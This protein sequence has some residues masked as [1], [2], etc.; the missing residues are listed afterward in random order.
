MTAPGID[1][2]LHVHAGGTSVVID[3]PERTAPALAYW[4]PS[5]GDLDATELD[6]V[7][8][9]IRPQQRVGDIDHPSP[10]SLVPVQAEGWTGSPG[11][12]GHRRRAA[13]APSF[14]CIS[15]SISTDA[16]AMRA[17]LRC[18]DPDA[19]LDLDITLDVLPSGLVR[20]RL[21][22]RN[23][24]DGAYTV[25]ALRAVFPVPDAATEL[26]DLTGRWMRERIPQRHPLRVGRFARESR[27]G[28]PG[29][30]A[31]LLLVAGEPGFGFERGPV[32]AVHV[33][34]SGNHELAAERT[35][36]AGT[37]LTGAELPLPGEIVVTAGHEYASPWVYASHGNGLDELASRFHEFLRARESHPH[38]PRPVVMNVWEAVYFDHELPKLS[39]LAELGASIGAE[40]FMLDDGWFLGRRND[41]CALGDWYVDPDVWPEGLAPIIDR[42]HELGMAFGIWVEPEMVSVDSVLARKHPEWLLGPGG[43]TPPAAKWQQV[44]DLSNP[45]A[46]AYIFERLDWLLR[47]HDVQYLKWDHNRDVL[48]PGAELTGFATL[49]EHTL[50][51]YRLMDELRRRHPDVEFENCASGGARIDLEILS[52]T[53]RTWVSDCADPMERAIVQQYTGLLM[54]LEMTGNDISAATSHTTGRTS[55]I[56]L[57]GGVAILGHLGIQW[58]LTRTTEQE[59]ADLAA[60]VAAYKRHRGLLHSGKAVS[61]DHHDPSVLIRGVVA[62]DRSRALFTLAQLT[63]S[64]AP[65]G[66]RIRFPGLDPD[67][68]YDVRVDTPA[69]AVRSRAYTPAPWVVDGIR[70]T[71]R[72]LAAVGLEAPVLDPEQVIIITLD[73]VPGI[74]SGTR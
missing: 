43:R 1:R 62:P 72:T 29:A 26:L 13:F 54:P 21:V 48:E 65:S 37:V 42:V 39:E 57:R 63:S 10:V 27:K 19:G 15:H 8:R 52:R 40:L 66:G 53:E 46:Y 33:A 20:Q 11:L 55:W 32:Y 73:S 60:W 70:L 30:D 64:L 59:R 5:L 51:V 14:R 58:D 34:W 7:V 24:D 3:L 61:L 9:A 25:Q 23:V 71:G 49:H 50:A 4:G 17:V 16:G 18:S 12:E 69:H 45:E 35:I 74:P 36:L 67:T 41:R 6:A 28:R 31:S 47:E 56:D 22:L 44:L 38:A 68:R 2:H